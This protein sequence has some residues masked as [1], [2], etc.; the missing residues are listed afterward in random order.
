MKKLIILTSILLFGIL[1]QAQTMQDSLV[2]N[3]ISK[4]V[5]EKLSN[6]EL[7]NL[8]KDVEHMKYNRGITIQDDKKM[9]LAQHLNSRTFIIGLIISV[10]IFIILLISIPFYFNVQKTKSFHRM[11]IGF[12]EKGQEIPNE[13]IL[14]VPQAKSDLRRSIILISTGIAISLVLILIS[15]HGRIWSIGIIPVVMGIGY[16]VSSR[17]DK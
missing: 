11:I 3:Q 2:P 8:I 9:F 12:V 6:E 1:C 7:I 13:I 16:L 10:M 14:S 5:V 15:S 4:E 17:L